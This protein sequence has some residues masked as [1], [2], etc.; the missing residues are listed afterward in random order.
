MTVACQFY[1]SP[2]NHFLMS[3][4]VRGKREMGRTGTAEQLE[5]RDRPTDLLHEAF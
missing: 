4:T 3:K 1:F 2:L 5:R